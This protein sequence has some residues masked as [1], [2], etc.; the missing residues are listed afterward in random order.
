MRVVDVQVFLTCQKFVSIFHGKIKFFLSF[1]TVAI[2]QIISKPEQKK[3]YFIIIIIIMRVVTA[4]ASKR[5]RTYYTCKHTYQIQRDRERVGEKKQAVVQP[6]MCILSA[7]SVFHIENHKLV[8]TE[9]TYILMPTNQ[10]PLLESYL[11]E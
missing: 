4:V 7:Q 9:N 3:I 10:Q 8:R 11:Y 5:T 2:N 1:I 6:Q